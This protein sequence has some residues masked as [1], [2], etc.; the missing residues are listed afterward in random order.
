VQL[1][2]LHLAVVLASKETAAP[3]RLQPVSVEGTCRAR[4]APRPQGDLPPA[5]GLAG[6][7][8]RLRGAAEARAGTCEELVMLFVALLRALG[9]PARSV[10]CRPRRRGARAPCLDRPPAPHAAR[11]RCRAVQAM[12]PAGRPASSSGERP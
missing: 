10:R 4:R 9:L 12:H 8:A 3:S 5:R 6:A 11:P 2:C 1:T 7:V